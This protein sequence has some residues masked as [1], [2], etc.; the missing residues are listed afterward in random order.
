M[1]LEEF[2][3]QFYNLSGLR[4]A[5]LHIN[6]GSIGLVSTSCKKVFVSLFSFFASFVLFVFL[7]SYHTSCF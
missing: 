1:F 2:L 6:L 5:I 3:F 4:F 7:L